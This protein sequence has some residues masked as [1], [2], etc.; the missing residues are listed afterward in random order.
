MGFGNCCLFCAFGNEVFNFEMRLKYGHGVE[1]L[2]SIEFEVI[3]P[4]LF[5][6]WSVN[7]S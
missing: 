3:V 7:T 2:L 6:I 5:L 4:W 1:V